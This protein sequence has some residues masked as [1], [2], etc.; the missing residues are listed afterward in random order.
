MGPVQEPGALWPGAVIAARRG[1]AA[2][3]A[4][5]AITLDAAKILGVDATVGSL[6]AGKDAD[7]I[8]LSAPIT[9]PRARLLLCV[10]DGKVVFR[11][12]K[13]GS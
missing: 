2:D 10:Q 6:K 7:L 3:R 13:E 12:P 1:L 11:A 8:V 5:R 9:D 4:L